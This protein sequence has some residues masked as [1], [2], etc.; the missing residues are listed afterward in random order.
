MPDE[1][2]DGLD[3][4]APDS[5]IRGLSIYGF[6]DELLYVGGDRTVVADNWF[7]VTPTGVVVEPASQA[8]DA[9]M[10]QIGAADVVVGG[11]LAA[12]GNVLAA[13]A[14]E[15]L[16]TLSA[17][18]N[19]TVENN[20]FGVA[21]DGTTALGTAGDHA[22]SLTGTS[23]GTVIRNNQ[24]ANLALGAIEATRVVDVGHHRQRVRHRSRPHGITPHPG[25]AGGLQ[26]RLG[27]IRWHRGR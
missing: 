21:T 13:V 12:D 23:T 17:A 15:G 5:E 25:G 14:I 26:R 6:A 1:G 8:A 2:D 24:F 7:G 20:H 3:V 27:A 18:S 16:T 19:L 9:R 10:I 11:P 22:V 4:Q